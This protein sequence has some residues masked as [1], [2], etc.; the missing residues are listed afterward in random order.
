MKIDFLPLY[1][2]KRDISPLKQFWNNHIKSQKNHK[3]KNQIVLVFK[4]VVLHSKHTI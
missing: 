3:M 2:L 1:F 4:L